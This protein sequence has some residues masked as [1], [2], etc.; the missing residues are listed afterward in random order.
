MHIFDSMKAAKRQR[1]LGSSIARSESSCVRMV[2]I[3]ILLLGLTIAM[4]GSSK[5][6]KAE[7]TLQG[8]SWSEPVPLTRDG[9]GPVLVSDSAG[10]IHLLYVGFSEDEDTTEA[11]TIYYMGRRAGQWQAPMDVLFSS[12]GPANLNAVAVDA[13]GYLHVAWNNAE[14]AFHSRAH[15]QEAGNASKWDTRL[16]M[17]ARQPVGDMALDKTGRL[18]QVVVDTES[19]IYLYSDD[20]GDSWSAPQTVDRIINTEEL[21]IGGARVAVDASGIIHV[22]WHQNARKVDWNYWSVWYGRSVDEG[23]TWQVA[24]V[25]APELGDSDIAIDGDD[26]VH[27]VYGRNIGF[28]DGRWH[29]WSSNSGDTWSNPRPLYPVAEKASGITGGYDF[30]LDSADQLHMVNSY[31]G[32]GGDASAWHLVW[33]GTRWSEPEEL[34]DTSFHAHQPRLTISGGN[35]LD[36]VALAPRQGSSLLFLQGVADSPAVEL[37]PVPAPVMVPESELTAPE[38]GS[39]VVRTPATPQI[40]LSEEVRVAPPVKAPFNSLVVGVGAALV[41][42][43]MVVVVRLRATR[44]R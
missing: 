19:V 24:E 17:S 22:T 31:G 39:Q 4:A 8:N 30:A 33:L 44:S 6:A 23:N 38:G 10:D 26:N 40:S 1:E 28:R 15:V 14:K 21:A 41:V 2:S 27:L 34:L 5:V 9:S 12:E 36:F 35:E 25:A 3:T 20:G 32:V 13:N 18:H 42:L 16:V 43:L 37:R 11:S 7:W 29:Q